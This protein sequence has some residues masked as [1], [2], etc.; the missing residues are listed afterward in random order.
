MKGLS[1]LSSWSPNIPCC[2]FSNLCVSG[3]TFSA[4]CLVLCLTGAGERDNVT[5]QTWSGL[6]SSGCVTCWGNPTGFLQ[7]KKVKLAASAF[8]ILL[9]A[10]GS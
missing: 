4:S 10:F 1:G 9:Y 2:Y 8:L 3:V 6:S 5:V 7:F